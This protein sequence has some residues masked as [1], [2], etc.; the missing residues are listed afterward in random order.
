MLDVHYIAQ[1]LQ[2]VQNKY[3]TRHFEFNAAQFLNL[4]ENK[5]TLQQQI[6]TVRGAINKNAKD[7]GIAKNDHALQTQ[8]LAQAMPLKH[9]LTTIQDAYT[10]AEND[11]QEFLMYLPNLPD[12]DVAV[13]KDEHDNTVIYVHGDTI[14]HDWQKPHDEIA[15]AIGMD[16]AAGAKLSGA[17]FTVLQGK[18]AKLH[19][20]LIA[21]MMNEHEARGYE[22]LY[23]PYLVKPEAMRGTGQ[24]PKFADD[25]FHIPEQD[26]YLIPT[27]EVPVTNLLADQMLQPHD[28]PKKFMA[29]TPCFRKE[30]GA[31]G[32]DTKGMIRQHQFDKIELVQCVMPEQSDQALEDICDAAKNILEKLKLPYRQVKLCTGD[33]GFGSAK[34]YDLEVWLPGQGAYR[35]IS[36]VTNF[37]EFQAR[38]M[39]LRVKDG[40]NRIIP[41]TLNGSGLAIGRTLVA[42]IENYQQP[43]GTIVVPEVLK[44]F[45]NCDVIHTK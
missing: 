8:L 25:M 33:M 29:H 43:D 28:L 6:E 35:E 19:R 1:N 40:K 16:A 45:M 24:L 30:V 26:L 4:F 9:Q 31:A 22:E 7:V 38:R 41:H 15:L 37:R 5:K 27:A 42:V 3:A 13:G 36:S 21:F 39:G 2:L 34:T 12:D 32:R 10:K 17:R 11:L 18:I 44:P 23:V 14:A 20:A